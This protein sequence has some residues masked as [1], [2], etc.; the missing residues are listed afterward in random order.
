VLQMLRT[1]RERT[2]ANAH[3]AC[4]Q[5]VTQRQWTSDTVESAALATLHAKLFPKAPSHLPA[6]FLHDL[7]AELLGKPRLARATTTVV[8]PLVWEWPNGDSDGKL[9]QFVLELLN[10]SGQVFLDPR[11]ACL[12]LDESFGAIF[13]HAPEALGKHLGCSS[14]G[15]VRVRIEEHRTGRLW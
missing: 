2:H 6:A 3:L 15:D 10:G 1:E 12:E 7:T 13:R 14:T 9:V 5:L 11:Q 8:L 4:V